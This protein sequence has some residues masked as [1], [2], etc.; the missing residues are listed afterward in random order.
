MVQN[1]YVCTVIV[2]DLKMDNTSINEHFLI[3]KK[4]SSA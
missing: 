3:A 1:Y 4:G 2:V